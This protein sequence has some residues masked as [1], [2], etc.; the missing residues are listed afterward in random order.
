MLSWQSSEVAVAEISH[1]WII[2]SDYVHG[3]T[4][5][6]DSTRQIIQMIGLSINSLQPVAY[7]SHKVPLLPVVTAKQHKRNQTFK[8]D[9]CIKG[10]IVRLVCLFRPT[11]KLLTLYISLHPSNLSIISR[12]IHLCILF[13]LDTY[14]HILQH[15]ILKLPSKHSIKG[16]DA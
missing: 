11:T 10:V 5:A 3:V 4:H 1:G 15:C 14:T 13:K 12:M 6:Y 7:G 9:L 8:C 2:W 16:Q